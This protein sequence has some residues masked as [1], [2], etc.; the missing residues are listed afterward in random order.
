[1]WCRASHGSSFAG[2]ISFILAIAG[3]GVTDCDQGF[4]DEWPGR[5]VPA[6]NAKRLPKGS[7]S[8]VAMLAV[9]TLRRRAG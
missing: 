2:D 4:S 6:L 1:M 7:R 9:V 5:R 8:I 3:Q